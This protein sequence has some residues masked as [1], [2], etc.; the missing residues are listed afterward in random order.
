MNELK[1]LQICFLGGGHITEILLENLL[2]NGV[3]DAEQVVVSSRGLARLTQLHVRFG[4]AILQD[5]VA[6]VR[7]ADVIIVAVRP[8]VVVDVVGEL[9]SAE[10]TP[11]QL[12]ISLAAG[13][14]FTR[15]GQLSAEQPIIRLMPNPPSRIGQGLIALCVSRQVSDAQRQLAF[16]LFAYLGKIVEVSEPELDLITSLTSPVA[17][18]AFLQALIEAGVNGGLSQDMATRIAA[19]TMLGTVQM[20]Q[21]S[22]SSPAE[23]VAEA[24]TPG[25]ISAETGRALENHDFAVTIKQAI[26][27]GANRATQLANDD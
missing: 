1:R 13:T 8:D 19:Q 16:D 4:V 15:Y 14:P 3:I 25:G 12:I 10:I 6:A 7:D 27:A 22:S 20:W 5:N 17:T 11:P 18:L 2:G 24:S 21:A 9:V 23:L 26:A